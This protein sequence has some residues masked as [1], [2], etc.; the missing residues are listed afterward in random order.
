MMSAEI[1][2]QFDNISS[3]VS[4]THAVAY[5]SYQIPQ[6]IYTKFA[7]PKGNCEL[8]MGM[9]SDGECECEVAEWKRNKNKEMIWCDV[10][11]IFEPPLLC[12]I[13]T[14]FFAYFKTYLFDLAF[15]SCCENNPLKT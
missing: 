12:S 10:M 2:N 14:K 9:E 15:G 8:E 3:P 6:K 5:H 1:S 13:Y 7:L 11:S 4:L